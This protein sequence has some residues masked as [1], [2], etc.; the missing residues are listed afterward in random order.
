MVRKIDHL[1][2]A[3]KDLDAALKTLEDGFGLK[4]T[5]REEVPSQKVTVAF[6]PVGESNIELLEPTHEDS[7]VAKFLAS[8]GEGLH[9]IALNTEDVAGALKK[10]EEGGLRL[11][12]KE[13]RPGAHGTRVGFVHPKSTFGVLIELV[14]K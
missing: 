4:S 12:D 6:V 10:A 13:P 3:V 5:G 9:H 7:A 11:I 2:I 1:G 8:R 14:Q